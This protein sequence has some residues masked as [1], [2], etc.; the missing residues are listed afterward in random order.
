MK[1]H[2]RIKSFDIFGKPVK[3]NFGDEGETHKTILGGF[4]TIIFYLGIIAFIGFRSYVMI[5]R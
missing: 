5:N 1:F 4:F 3:L 2:Q